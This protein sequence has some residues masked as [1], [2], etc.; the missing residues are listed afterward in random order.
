MSATETQSGTSTWALDASHTNVGFAVKHLMISTV[1]GQFS[2]VT[3][4]V[5][6]HG[7][8]YSTAQI[9]AEIDAPSI[10]TRNE[11]RDTHLRSAD[12]FDV[13]NFP[14]LT[15]ES[16]N[17][18]VKSENNLE[19][20][21]DLTIRGTTKPVTL[22]VLIE[23]HGKDPWG[24]DRTGFTA[25]TKIK[26]SEFGLTWNQVLEAGG[27]AVSDDIRITIDGELIRQ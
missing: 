14:K 17:V 23:G 22:A 5:T 11:Q 1:R 2:D 21:G 3:A 6:I 20:T 19:I 13:E 9:S 24:N 18:V 12:F 15:F 4:S 16:K 27:V 25:E 10:T 26:R 8:D 7:A